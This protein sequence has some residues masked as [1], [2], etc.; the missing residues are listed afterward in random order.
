MAATAAVY[1]PRNPQS[2][3]YYRCV[4][5]HFETFIQVYDSN[6]SRGKRQEAGTDDAVPCILEAQGDSNVFRKNWARLI[7]KIYETDPLVC[8]KCRGTMHI[9][10]SIEDPS[11]I[12]AIL[13]HL[14]LWLVKSRP[15]PKIHDPPV[16]MHGTRRPSAT[17]VIDDHSQLTINDDHYCRDPQYSWDE[18]IQA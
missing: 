16:C 5:D 13:K 17:Y 12:R 1:R 11:V 7:Q 8:P 2:S 10:S 15:P 4:E 9:I 6:V 14:K 3:D 18:Y